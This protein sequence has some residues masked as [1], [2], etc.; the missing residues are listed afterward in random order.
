MRWETGNVHLGSGQAIKAVQRDLSMRK[1][2]GL[3]L[4]TKAMTRT[5][6]SDWEKWENGL[7]FG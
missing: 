2:N 7:G 1:A 6:I 5:T 3:R 4:A